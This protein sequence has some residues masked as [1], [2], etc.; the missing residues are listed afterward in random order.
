MTEYISL[1]DSLPAVNTRTLVI[2]CAC[3]L[4][5]DPGEEPP[6]GETGDSCQVDPLQYAPCHPGDPDPCGE[7]ACVVQT[8]PFLTWGCEMVE[9]TQSPGHPCERHSECTSGVCL[10]VDLAPFSSAEAD[11][12]ACAVPCQGEGDCP[13]ESWCHPFGSPDLEYSV[14][15]WPH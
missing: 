4:A 8:G 15:V 2:L 11:Y 14:C 5:C 7:G 9:A 6:T 12:G 10:P 3:L 1:A 13:G